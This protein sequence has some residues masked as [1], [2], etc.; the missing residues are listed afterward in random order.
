MTRIMPSATLAIVFAPLLV[1]GG[2]GTS[3]GPQAGSTASGEVLPGSVSDAM[4][5]T[6]GSQAHAPFAPAAAHAGGKATADASAGSSEAAA[7]ATSAAEPEPTDQAQP[8][9]KPTSSA[10]PAT[11]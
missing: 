2:C 1:L 10:K 9:P 3:S 4:L 8:R 11:P 6:N 7:D 5:D